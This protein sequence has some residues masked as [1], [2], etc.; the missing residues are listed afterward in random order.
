[1]ASVVEAG[2]VERTMRTRETKSKG[3]LHNTLR[4]TWV[5]LEVGN[6]GNIGGEVRKVGKQISYVDT[7]TPISESPI[8]STGAVV[9]PSLG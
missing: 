4:E 9:A 2:E 1:M 5:I 3:K 7:H 6:I 8:A